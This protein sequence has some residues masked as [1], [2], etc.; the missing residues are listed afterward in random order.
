M[1]PSLQILIFC[2]PVSTP[3]AVDDLTAVAPMCAPLPDH[4]Q[5]LW[6]LDLTTFEWDCLPLK[7]APSARSGHRVALYKHKMVLF[8]GFYDTGK[9]VK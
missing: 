7:G 8:G 9:E 5:D 1:P 3:P 6:R 2:L 4:P